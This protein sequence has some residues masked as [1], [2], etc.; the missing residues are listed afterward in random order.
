MYD[1]HYPVY[2]VNLLGKPQ[3]ISKNELKTLL[4]AGN[5]TVVLKTAE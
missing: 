3:G 1:S 4:G 5:V 2:Y